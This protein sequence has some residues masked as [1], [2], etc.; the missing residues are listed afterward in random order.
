MKKSEEKNFKYRNFVRNI[1]I[2]NE[3][4][5]L[6]KEDKYNRISWNFP[7]GKIEENE[8]PLEAVIRETQEEIGIKS[9]NPVL[10]YQGSMLFDGTE[11]NGW[12]F[13]SEI[14]NYDFCLEDKILDIKFFSPQEIKTLKT[15]VPSFIWSKIFENKLQF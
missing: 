1:I 14:N 15:N 13:S 11:W 8:T 6:I 7:G 10:F 4:I 2:K 3:K 9:F 12:Y 5:L